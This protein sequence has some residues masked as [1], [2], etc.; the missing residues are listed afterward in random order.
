[1][2]RPAPRRAVRWAVAG[3]ACAVF[4]AGAGGVWFT[5]HQARLERE[6]A[7]QAQGRQ[8]FRG[9]ASTLGALSGRVA[10]H[11][12]DLPAMATRCTN[13]HTTGTSAAVNTPAFAPRLNGQTLTQP[14]P[15]RGGPPSAYDAAALCRVLRVGIDPAW[16]MVRQEMPRYAATD[17]QCAALWAFLVA[18]EPV[19]P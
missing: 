4:V 6:V 11:A 13:C 12:D 5:G 3:L 10:G 2:T 16:V 18:P 7:L 15:R 8:L 17:V 19:Q 1:M 9:E 14:M